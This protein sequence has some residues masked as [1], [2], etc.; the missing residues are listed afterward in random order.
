[1]YQIKV[2]SNTSNIGG[3][4]AIESKVTLLSPK[5]DSEIRLPL[6]ILT[7]EIN[8]TLVEEIKSKHKSQLK[9]AFIDLLSKVEEET[10]LVIS[11]TKKDLLFD[12]LVS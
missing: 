9:E 7:K 2:S 8:Q 11:G 10:Y 4:Q 6:V 5:G 3:N 12:I 1:M